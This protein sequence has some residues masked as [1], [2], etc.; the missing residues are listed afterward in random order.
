MKKLF[1]MAA[2]VFGGFVFFFVVVGVIAINDDSTTPEPTQATPETIVLARGCVYAFNV[3]SLKKL[4]GLMAQDGQAADAALTK[5][6]EAGA[7]V[8][9]VSPRLVGKIVNRE[10]APFYQIE[11]GSS[12]VWIHGRCIIP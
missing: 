10:Q 7:V 11:T 12:L 1:K 2:L 5:M 8:K 3:N 9:I 6:L 4:A